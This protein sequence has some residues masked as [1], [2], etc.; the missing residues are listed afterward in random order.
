[1]VRRIVGGDVLCRGGCTDG[2][3]DDAYG[4]SYECRQ[5]IRIRDDGDGGADAAKGSGLTG[6]IDRVE[7]H[8][9]TMAISSPIGHGTSLLV[10]IPFEVV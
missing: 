5:W 8:G 9:G 4:N 7:A 6:L 2:H 1:M 3:N 10:K